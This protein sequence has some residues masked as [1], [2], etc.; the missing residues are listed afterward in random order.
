MGP[1]LSSNTSA[2]EIH[3]NL[4]HPASA[5][6]ILVLK[7]KKKNLHSEQLLYFGSISADNSLLETQHMFLFPHAVP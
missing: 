6:W 7:K 2:H 5:S 1:L 4:T 3:S